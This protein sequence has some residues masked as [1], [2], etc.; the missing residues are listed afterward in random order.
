MCSTSDLQKLYMCHCGARKGDF[1]PYL[2][3]FKFGYCCHTMEQAPDV[4]N[5]IC[6]DTCLQVL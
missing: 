1:V 4:A 5:F 3:G 2:V 6:S